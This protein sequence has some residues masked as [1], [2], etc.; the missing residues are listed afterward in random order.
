MQRAEMFQGTSCHV[1][2]TLPAAGWLSGSRG[3][4]W[5]C[6]LFQGLSQPEVLRALI[7][8]T[9]R[10]HQP[11]CDREGEVIWCVLGTSALCVKPQKVCLSSACC[12]GNVAADWRTR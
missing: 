2:T 8:T 4:T 9:H 6:L 10:F 7:P 11:C 5:V 1:F 3:E 12:G